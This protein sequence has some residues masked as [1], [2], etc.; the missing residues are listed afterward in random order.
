MCPFN[1][2]DIPLVKPIVYSA[3]RTWYAFRRLIRR[4][5]TLHRLYSFPAGSQL[6]LLGNPIVWGAAVEI[7]R[8]LRDPRALNFRDSVK[9]VCKMVSVA[10][11][12]VAQ[13]TVTALSLRDVRQTS[14]VTE[15]L[16]ALSLTTSLSAVFYSTRE[17]INMTQLL[18]GTQ[19]RQW[20]RGVRV[21]F[22]LESDRCFEVC[23]PNT[24]NID[25]LMGEDEEDRKQEIEHRCFVPSVSAV[26]GV[27]APVLMLLVSVTTLLIGF[28]VYFGRIWKGHLDEGRGKNESK[29]VF[30]VFIVGLVVSVFFYLSGEF[31]CNEH[32]GTEDV[33]IHES[34]E[35]YL[36]NNPAKAQEWGLHV[37]R[38]LSI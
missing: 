8:D 32:T 18:T 28:G 37:D 35:E 5:Y 33:I 38:E 12:L 16:F 14:W 4:V 7:L 36:D 13:I 23:E 10:G 17:Y 26:I 21:N 34:L 15:A 1:I 22:I 9:G 31:L 30:I 19:V 29:N 2:P 20:I 3:R 24:L 25:T 27:S 6:V 11:A